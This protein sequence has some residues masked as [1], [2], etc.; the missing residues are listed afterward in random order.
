M[1]KEF[2]V[3][4]QVK[5]KIKLEVTLTHQLQHQIYILSQVHDQSTTAETWK[6]LQEN[7]L[8]YQQFPYRGKKEK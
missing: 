4:L 8:H 2:P 3:N 7:D 6:G 5:C 1:G